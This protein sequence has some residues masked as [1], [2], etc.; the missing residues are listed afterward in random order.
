MTDLKFS[1]P[2]GDWVK[3]GVDW[4]VASASGLF[5]AI[6][7]LFGGLYDLLYAALSWPPNWVLA[8][9]V[10]IAALAVRGWRLALGAAIG[11]AFIVA[12]D[13]WDNAMRTLALVLVA[14]IIAVAIA[15][16]VGIAAARSDA[17]SRAV[18]PVL[19]FFQTMP[20]MV[21]LVPAIILF[22]TGVVPGIFATIIFAIAPGVRMTEL[23][24]RGVD[25]EVIEAAR[26]FGSTE[27]RILRQV[28]LP[29]ALPSIMAGVNQVI[30]L[31][32]SMVVIAGMVGAS[33]LGQQVTYAL[34]SIDVGLGFE[35]GMSVVVLAMLL[36]RFTG[37]VGR[38]RRRRLSAAEPE[39]ADAAA[40]EAAAEAPA[41][42]A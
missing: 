9:L 6:A 20:A 3:A 24:I 38:R 34:G 15:L 41:A 18:R 21:Y 4:L 31:S 36:D 12:V 16:P 29:L 14:S 23:G 26:A 13:Q 37:A 28:Q 19:D 40:S 11:L 17:V 42:T 1:I 27:G 35:A 8:A 2:F 10:V 32:L 30:M 22:G 5:A 39:R 25:R 7:W 33:G